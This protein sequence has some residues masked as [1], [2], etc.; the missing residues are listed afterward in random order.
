MINEP[1][2]IK[3]EAR[4]RIFNFG[5]KTFFQE[6]DRLFFLDKDSKSLKK[7]SDS[8]ADFK[9]SPDLK[10]IVYYDNYEIQ[11]FHLESQND[12]PQKKICEK[13][14]LTRYTEKIDQL[15]WLTCH[16]LIFNTGEKIKI[17]E[18]D[19]RNKINIID[20]PSLEHLNNNIVINE[21]SEE[22][23]NQKMFWDLNDKILYI[24]KNGTLFTTEDILPH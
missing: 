18:I 9:V 23:Q 16:Y 22:N 10:K 19:D 7:V 24:L 4:R 11:I 15:F 5:N 12:Q 1:F 20:L 13:T 6:S 8:I 3:N 21:N 14:F 17:A 2:E